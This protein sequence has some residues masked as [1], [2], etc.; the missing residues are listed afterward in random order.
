MCQYK[1]VD[2]YSININYIQMAVL[3]GNVVFCNLMCS[4]MGDI[5]IFIRRIGGSASH[6]KS[7]KISHLGTHLYSFS[8]NS[9][10]YIVRFSTRLTSR[11]QHL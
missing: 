6:Y 9:E 3:S 7:N 4:K 5:V 8:V 10:Y 1:C 11:G 2:M